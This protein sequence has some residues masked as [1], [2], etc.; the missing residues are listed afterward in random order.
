[1]KTIFKPTIFTFV[2]AS[3][4][5]AGCA[6]AKDKSHTVVVQFGSYTTVKNNWLKLFLPEARA[7]VANLKFCFKRLRFKMANELTNSDPT[8]DSDNID[9]NLGEIDI[10]SGCFKNCCVR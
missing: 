10:S 2:I 1:M 3:M 7:S 5:M 6:P 4:M 8:Q 9:F